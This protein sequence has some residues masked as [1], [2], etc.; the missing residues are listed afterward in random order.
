MGRILGKFKE[1]IIV[2]PDFSK[3]I[4][5][6][7]GKSNLPVSTLTILRDEYDPSFYNCK[8]ND[9]DKSNGIALRNVEGKG[10]YIE[11]QLIIH[12]A[13]L[14]DWIKKLCYINYNTV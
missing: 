14:I 12:P 2:N 13:S 7:L 10:V 11:K 4:L 6:L 3:T 1:L 5:S 9:L 8:G